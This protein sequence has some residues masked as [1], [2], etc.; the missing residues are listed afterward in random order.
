MPSPLV[1]S[2]MIF[3]NPNKIG[4]SI[5]V[6]GNV[7]GT[8]ALTMTAGAHG[9]NIIICTSGTGSSTH[10]KLTLPLSSV[11]TKG[12]IYTIASGITGTP[13]SNGIHIVMT[14]ADSI[15]GGT[16]GLGLKGSTVGTVG[17]TI[18]LMDDGASNYWIV[19]HSGGTGGA[20]SLVWAST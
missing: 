10:Q 2:R 11:A 12:T 5:I 19:Q 9:G 15:N 17:A 8:S 20:T 3:T 4:G 18:S 13:T 1:T 6:N 16:S 7:S 14:S